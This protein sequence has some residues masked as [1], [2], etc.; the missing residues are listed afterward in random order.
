[1]RLL[2]QLGLLPLLWLLLP[3]PCLLLSL[4]LLLLPIL[5]ILTLNLFQHP[6]R[7]RQHAPAAQNIVPRVDL[8][9][10]AQL[11]QQRLSGEPLQLR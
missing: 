6:H 11:L 9:P 8:G 3:L 1:M 5:F 2:L 10:L 4:L 7:P